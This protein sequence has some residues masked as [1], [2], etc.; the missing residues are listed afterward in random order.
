MDDLGSVPVSRS[1][2][3][4]I[5]AVVHAAVAGVHAVDGAGPIV[6]CLLAAG[7]GS[8]PLPGAEVTV[9][10]VGLL[11]GQSV[12]R[13]SRARSAAAVGLGFLTVL[14]RFPRERG[15]H[16]SLFDDRIGV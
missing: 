4:E 12:E 11:A 14:G 6:R 2:G 7:A 5:H 3:G 1:G 10:L 13:A 15:V 9:P 8:G 16:S